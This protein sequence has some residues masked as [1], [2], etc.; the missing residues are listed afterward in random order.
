MSAS[1]LPG[2]D[3][4]LSYR[5]DTVPQ[6]SGHVPIREP[7]SG[8]ARS[9]DPAVTRAE[10]PVVVFGFEV[11]EGCIPEERG[12]FWNPDK[13]DAE[14]RSIVEQQA[15][16]TDWRDLVVYTAAANFVEQ[17]LPHDWDTVW[18]SSDAI[19]WVVQFD[20]AGDGDDFEIRKFEARVT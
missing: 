4:A 14:A 13:R 1:V 11:S 3:L 10:M 15:Q 2:R 20:F 9:E 7:R 8:V 18:T 12:L 19:A 16:H 5:I 6:V 17:E